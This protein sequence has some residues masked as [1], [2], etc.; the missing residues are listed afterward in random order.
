MAD[1]LVTLVYLSQ[2]AAFD[3]LGKAELFTVTNGTDPIDIVF[4]DTTENCCAYF[5]TPSF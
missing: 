4:T 5:E 1:S 2:S 3:I